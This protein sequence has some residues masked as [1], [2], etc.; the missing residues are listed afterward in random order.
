M[1]L[2]WGVI[3]VIPRGS[4]E[5]FKSLLVGQITHYN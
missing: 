5:R 3:F 4:D 1:T 2:H